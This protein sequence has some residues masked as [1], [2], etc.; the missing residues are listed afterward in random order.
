MESTKWCLVVVMVLDDE[1]FVGLLIK[2]GLLRG[3]LLGRSWE[4]PERLGVL[5][6]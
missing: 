4:I 1:I 2:K 5:L 6:P 3:G